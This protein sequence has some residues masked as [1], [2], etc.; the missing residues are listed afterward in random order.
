MAFVFRGR[1]TSLERPVAIKV[2]RPQLA[3]AIGAERF[4][5][6]A[7]HLANLSH[8]HLVSVHEAG[9]TDGLYYYVMDHIE[10]DTLDRVLARGP[11]APA[12]A[13][14]VVVGLLEAL[15]VVHANDLIHRD[16]KPENIFLQGEHPLL[17]DFGIAKC[18]LFERMVIDGFAFDV[19]LLFLCERLGLRVEE[20]AV[21]W[22]NSPHS[23]VGVLTDPPKM[24]R[25]VL[26]VRW[27]FRSGGY[28]PDATNKGS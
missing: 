23:T 3:T 16:V 18:P 27:R 24:L 11:L 22:R 6:E 9:E 7:K 28:R 4:V 13:I 8:P 21:T 15:E 20:A 1:D 12:L 5:R 14:Q 10:A 25:D 17:A 26:R 2:L 19:E